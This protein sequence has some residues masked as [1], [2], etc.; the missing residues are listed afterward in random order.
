MRRRSLLKATGVSTLT[1]GLAGCLG[2]LPFT[3]DEDEGDGGGG[4]D[5]QDTDTNPD[6]N[7]DNDT[8]SNNDTDS[9][10]DT[11]GEE[12]RSDREGG[13]SAD[14][15][16]EDDGADAGDSDS[17]SDSDG[18]EEDGDERHEDELEDLAPE[19]EDVEPDRDEYDQPEE[20]EIVERDPS[21]VAVDVDGGE[22]GGVVVVSG[23]V[24][25][26]SE[27]FIDAVDLDF[28]FYDSSG[29]YIGGQL[30]TVSDIDP[31]ASE[32]FEIELGVDELQGELA[33]AALASVNVYGYPGQR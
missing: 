26:V 31:G 17:D 19:Q 32:S 18:S 20:Q 28:E 3:D 8:D 25:N 5:N 23:S 10:T 30:V 14:G 22:D 13:G 16:D 4:E 1:I 15:G 12:E 11:D 6:A 29:E 24:T 27:E 7:G 9:D 2:R 21:D 33:E